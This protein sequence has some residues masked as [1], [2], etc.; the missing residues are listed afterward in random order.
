MTITV[1]A[2]TDMLRL[3]NQLESRISALTAELS[4]ARRFL[5]YF[6]SDD[7]YFFGPGTPK[8]CIENID[9][10]IGPATAA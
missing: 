1:D 10:L 2:D 8:K 4:D 3:V 9:A 7:R 6:Y 5:I